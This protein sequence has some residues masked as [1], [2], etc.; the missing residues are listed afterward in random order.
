M[1]KRRNVKKITPEEMAQAW[2]NFPCWVC[3]AAGTMWA[4]GDTWCKKCAPK[5]AVPKHRV[6]KEVTG[7][8]IRGDA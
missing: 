8:D 3:G 2:R 5:G 1:L 6:I 7:V 4:D